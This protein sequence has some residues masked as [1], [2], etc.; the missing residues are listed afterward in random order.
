MA[1]TSERTPDEWEE[2][3]RQLRLVIADQGRNPSDRE[4]AQQIL[5]AAMRQKPAPA[6]PSS[7]DLWTPK[8]VDDYI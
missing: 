2:L 5:A 7:H 8:W 3:I 4:R 1:L 6:P